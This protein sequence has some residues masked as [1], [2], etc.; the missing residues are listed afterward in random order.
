VIR[1]LFA[2]DLRLLADAIDDLD[3]HEMTD[4]WASVRPTAIELEWDGELTEG[5]TRSR[6]GER[7]IVL[8]DV[9]SGTWFLPWASPRS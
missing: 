3:N 9:D 8:F 1:H 2:G 6:L 4:T 5:N 7:P